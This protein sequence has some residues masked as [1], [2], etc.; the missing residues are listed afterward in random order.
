VEHI[1][2]VREVIGFIKDKVKVLWK[3]MVAPSNQ[4]GQVGWRNRK[5]RVGFLLQG[6]LNHR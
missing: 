5:K 3:A 4:V 6:I 2:V 1:D